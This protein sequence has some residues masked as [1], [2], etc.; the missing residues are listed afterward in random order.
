MARRAISPDKLATTSYSHGTVAGGTFYMAGQVPRDSDGNVVGED[1]ESQTRK[2]FQNIGVLLD[3]IDRGFDDIAKV[4]VYI[5]EEQESLDGYKRVYE[6]RFTEPY[7]CQTVI[8]TRPL[9][10]SPVQ[11]EIEAEVPME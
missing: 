2:T 10:D 1:L 9:G 7:P 6:E 8:G 4:T 5:M 3:E 11:I